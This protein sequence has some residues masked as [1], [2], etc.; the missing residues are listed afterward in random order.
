MNAQRA[1]AGLPPA[2]GMI[3]I[4]SA[5]AALCPHLEWATAAVLGPGAAWRW[6]E[7]P[8]QPGTRRS[9]ISW[10]AYPGTGARLASALA[11]FARI[12]FEVTEDASPGSE[13][14]R[15][16]YTPALGRFAATVGVHGDVLVPEDRIRHAM[17]ETGGDPR[18]LR[19]ALDGLIGTAWD[20]EL[21]E[22]RYGSED[23]PIRWLHHVV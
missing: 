23:A 21:E 5:P 17:G 3:F 22:F 9:E 6:T 19:D 7:Q 16:C 12:R 20:E 18:L 8:A 1:A 13:G 10:T 4:H 14:T 15:F 11:E 2:R